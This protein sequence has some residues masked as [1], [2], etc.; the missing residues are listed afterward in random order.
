MRLT[1]TLNKTITIN[2]CISLNI[3]I[4]DIGQRKYSFPNIFDSRLTILEQKSV[5]IK[6]FRKYGFPLCENT[7]SHGFA[8]E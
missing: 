5:Y 7:G 2:I 6:I 4:L 8:L 1:F 3:V